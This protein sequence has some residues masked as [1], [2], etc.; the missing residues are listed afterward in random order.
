MKKLCMI[1]SVLFLAGCSTQEVTIG[2]SSTK[3]IYNVDVTNYVDDLFH[4]TVFVEGLSEENNIYNMPATVP[5]TYDVLNF[6]RFVKTFKAFD[7]NGNELASEHISVN[8]WK[9]S[10]TDKLAKIT[11]DVEDTFD[12]DIT[13]DDVMPMG[14]TGIENDFIVMNTFG[15][16]GFFEGLQSNPV[17][18]KIDYKSDWTIG[19]SLNVNDQGYYTAETYDRLADSPVLL[20]DLTVASTMVN[21]I[22]VG[23][24]VYSADT[25]ITADKIMKMAD[26]VLQSAGNIIGYSPV[27]NYNFLFCL[28]D[29]ET[30]T[31]NNFHGAGALEH[32]YSS[33]YT[34][35]ARGSLSNSTRDAMA[36]EFMHILTPLNLHSNIIQPFNFMEPTAPEHIWLYEGVTEWVSD[37]MQL[38]SGL[39]TTNE[40]LERFSHKLNVSDRLDQD[41][42]L[43]QLSREVY[44]DQAVMD[45]VNFYNKGAVTA[46]LLDIRLLE[47]SN[48]TRGLREVL[49]ELLEKYGKY[50]PFPENEFF[51]IIVNITYPEIEQFINNYIRGTKPLPYAEY[52]EKLGFNYIAERP[53]D[54]TKPTFGV[55][56]SLGDDN[57]FKL[58]SVSE[59]AY[60]AGL[61]EDDII[62]KVLGNELS[63][64]NAHQVFKDITAMNVGD[65]IDV[66]VERDSK[67]IDV[68]VILQQ[69]IDHHIFEDMDELT[70]EQKMLRNAWIR[71][72]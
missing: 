27:N 35:P 11:Y 3:I 36:H 19:T 21:D 39:I 15:V 70:A 69:R 42:S 46:A 34:Y 40:Y 44:S 48:G 63:M 55:E 38:R 17:E 49:L 32:S 26:E 2:K 62:V 53:S 41:I 60:N 16:L 5:G 28:M 72:L 24:Y 14:G 6:G 57:R 20:G 58:F 54:D 4:V 68:K 52:T 7:K 10:N 25:S 71:N 59:E 9:I 64:Q 56:I 31:R 12:A 45:F 47:L 29:W 23:V 1:L 50:K 43:M 30:F 65:S 66:V 33:L 37:I 22:K 18:L 13:E 67:E 61:R 51:E 8:Q